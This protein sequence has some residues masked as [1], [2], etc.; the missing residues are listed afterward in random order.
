MT[1]PT[2]IFTHPTAR[3]ALYDTWRR[4]NDR[5]QVSETRAIDNFYRLQLK[6]SKNNVPAQ[7]QDGGAA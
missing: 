6:V 5:G 1:R 3:K 4:F 7:S 2:S